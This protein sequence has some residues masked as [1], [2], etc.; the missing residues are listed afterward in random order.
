MMSKHRLILL[1]AALTVN[2]LF[3]V[4]FADGRPAKW[5]HGSVMVHHAHRVETR[6]RAEQGFDFRAI[7]L[8]GPTDE[9]TLSG[10]RHEQSVRRFKDGFP[11]QD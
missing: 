6:W 8:S 1:A 3:A 7:T 9:L 11:L 2:I 5:V 4:V 10:E